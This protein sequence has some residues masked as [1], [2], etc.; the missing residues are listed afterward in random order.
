MV[1]GAYFTITGT[2]NWSPV[3]V[4][5]PIGLLVTAILHGN[6]WRDIADDAR[7]GIGTLSTFMGRKWAHLVYISLITSAYLAVVI[8]ILLHALPV[9]SLLA[10][11]SMPFLI[12]LVGAAE[13]GIQ[14]QQR[15]IA[16]IDLET[17]KL[18]A[19]FGLLYVT[20][21]VVGNII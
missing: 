9:T 8:G 20:G 1:V 2:I 16:K 13:L 4:S 15:A 19:A 18:H 11:L 6:E 14:G 12:H 21:L 3:I 5:V 10:F 17:A 7:Y